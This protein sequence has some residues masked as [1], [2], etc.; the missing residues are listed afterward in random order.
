MRIIYFIAILLIIIG[1][2]TPPTTKKPTN[3]PKI[4]EGAR[5]MDVAA[6]YLKKQL[7]DNV[8]F[9]VSNS[10]NGDWSILF[11]EDTTG[12]STEDIMK[13][14]YTLEKKSLIVGDLNKDGTDDFALRSIGGPQMGGMY[15]IDWY[16]FIYS[17]N[18]W[19]PIPNSF[20]GAKF[21]EIEDISAIKKGKIYTDTRPLDTDTFHHKDT[22]I[23]KE[24]YFS[25]DSILKL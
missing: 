15:I 20:G 14:Y 23:K 18:F 10:G 2:V 1:C 8:I 5:Y 4:K 19:I 22:I 24:Y 12:I 7:E 16:I 17:S 3:Q 21:N 6:N 25:N 11:A 13:E 9:E